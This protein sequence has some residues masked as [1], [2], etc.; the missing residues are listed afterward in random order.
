MAEQVTARIIFNHN[1]NILLLKY[2]SLDFS[3]FLQ[4]ALS[5]YS[6]TCHLLPPVCPAT[7]SEISRFVYIFQFQCLDHGAPFAVRDVR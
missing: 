4:N 1:N 2:Q 7:P 5:L 6:F 3:L